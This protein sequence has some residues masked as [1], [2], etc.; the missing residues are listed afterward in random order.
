MNT[1]IM[2]FPKD[3]IM[4][5]LTFCDCDT[6]NASNTSFMGVYKIDIIEQDRSV[7]IY[8]DNEQI[9]I[10]HKPRY[11][12][13]TDMKQVNPAKRLFCEMTIRRESI[14]DEE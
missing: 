2:V 12:L 7:G 1:I 13:I 4:R 8:V 11:R 6:I 5:I 10:W 9:A 14:F 3:V